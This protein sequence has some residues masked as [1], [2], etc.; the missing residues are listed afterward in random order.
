MQSKEWTCFLIE[1][2]NNWKYMDVTILLIFKGQFLPFKDRLQLSLSLVS[3]YNFANEKWSFSWTSSPSHQYYHVWRGSQFCLTKSF[4]D[5]RVK[6]FLFL[7]MSLSWSKLWLCLSCSCPLEIKWQSP[8]ILLFW[9]KQPK[10]TFVNLC[11]CNNKWSR[12]SVNK[13]HW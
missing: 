3:Q 9:L 5:K 8:T 4:I 1:S 7:P 10:L 6:F 2:L 12:I 11:D 13:E